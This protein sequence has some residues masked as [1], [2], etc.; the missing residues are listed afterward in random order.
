[1]TTFYIRSFLLLCFLQAVVCQ[2]SAA[3]CADG[4][5]PNSVFSDTTIAF[6]TGVT[7]TEVKF[8]QFDPEQGMVR[9]VKLTVTMIGVIDDVNMQNKSNGNTTANFYYIRSD[10]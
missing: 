2:R 8:P 3:Q 6:E 4:S 7:S 1:M 5:T 10:D 9:C